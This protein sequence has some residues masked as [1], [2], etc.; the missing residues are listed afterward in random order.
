MKSRRVKAGRR[1][2]RGSSSMAQLKF[3]YEIHNYQSHRR[4][5]EVYRQMLTRRY[6][7][8][9]SID[10]ADVVVLHLEPHNYESLY[11]RFPS[12]RT[13]YVVSYC[14]W[15]ASELPEIYQRS[16]ALVQEV[17]TCSNYCLAVIRKHHPRVFCVPHTMERERL[18]HDIDDVIIRR[19]ICFDPKNYYFLS[20]G[21]TLGARKNLAGLTSLFE[22][23]ASSMPNARLIV[24]GLPKDPILRSPDPR[25]IYLPLMLSESQ[26]NA[27]YQ[28]SDVYVSAHHSEGWGLTLSDAM[29]FGKPVVGTGYSGNLE[30]M[31]NYNSFLVRFTENHIR[32]EDLFGL[33]TQQMKWADPDFEHLRDIMQSLY[34]GTLRKEA[35]DKSKRAL[36]DG[37]KFST[38]SVREL[39]LG[40]MEEIRRLA[41]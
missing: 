38:D 15:E 40:R 28:A 26:I 3:W 13:K 20:I 35:A 25:I 30:F 2:D 17:W 32:Q 10:D 14:V 16:L 6:S 29:L 34:D 23:M 27:L 41:A 31:N 9:E 11:N 12:L 37:N 21:R 1:Q 5:A 18:N 8:A 36:E 19:L 39:V 4:V 33:F 7:S 22:S 24:K